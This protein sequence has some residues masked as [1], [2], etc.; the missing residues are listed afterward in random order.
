M[1]KLLPE[2]ASTTGTGP[3]QS[4]QEQP[5]DPTMER[6]EEMVDKLGEQIGYYASLA[7]QRIRKMAALAREEAE[8]IWAEAQHLRNGNST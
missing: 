8:D 1:N 2:N 5:A 3:D 7:G 4:T 6:A